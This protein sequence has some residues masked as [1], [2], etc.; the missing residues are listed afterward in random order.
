M[1]PPMGIRKDLQGLPPTSSGAS[2]SISRGVSMIGV[3]WSPVNQAYLILWNESVLAIKQ[4][5]SDV[6]EW[7]REHDLSTTDES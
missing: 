3:L 5:K 6:D 7:L 2:T 4:S 1:A